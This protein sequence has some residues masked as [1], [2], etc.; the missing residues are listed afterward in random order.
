MKKFT[1]ISMLL[2][3]LNVHAFK[4]EATKM[5]TEHSETITI[6]ESLTGS[7]TKISA[8]I[9]DTYF[10]FTQESENVYVA[11]ITTGPNYTSGA[12]G[13]GNFS[14]GIFK[15]SHVSPKTT[16]ILLCIED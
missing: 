10:S 1:I 8:D 5:T 6:K 4:C 7:A 15:L 16:H 3:T 14:N 13:K 2:V 11:M 9:Q 12:L